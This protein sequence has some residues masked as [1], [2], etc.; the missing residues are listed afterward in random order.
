MLAFFQ[1]ENERETGDLQD[2]K[3]H[4]YTKVDLF[5]PGHVQ[6]QHHS[7]WQASKDEVGHSR[8]T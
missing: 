3:A 6:A 1:N 7:P 5:C 4:G 8:E 2:A